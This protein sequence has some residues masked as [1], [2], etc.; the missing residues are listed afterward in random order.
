MPKADA[1]EL[2][3]KKIG[4]KPSGTV[5][6]CRRV[7]LSPH[8]SCFSLANRMR[9][10]EEHQT[11]SPFSLVKLPSGGLGLQNANIARL[12]LPGAP[13]WGF[14]RLNWDTLRAYTSEYP[15]PPV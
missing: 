10:L 13:L 9:S 15:I 14:D 5:I 3:P 12:L 8:S 1:T 7:I 4:Y 6:P 11:K 2:A